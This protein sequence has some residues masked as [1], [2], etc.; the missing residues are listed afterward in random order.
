MRF[1]LK[2]I[3]TVLFIPFFLVLLIAITLRFQLL[4]PSFWENVFAVNGTYSKLSVSINKNLEAQTIAE[5][6][7]GSDVKIFTDLISPDN[8]KD[9]I[10]RNIVNFLAF[11]NGRANQII[12]YVPINKIPKSLLSANFTKLT[13]QM[14]LTDLLKEFNVSGIDLSQIQMISRAGTA[15]WVFLTASIIIS[16]LLL[17]ILYLLIDSGKRLLGPSIA[18]ILAGVAALA[19]FLLGTIIKVN[20]TKDLANSSNTGDAIIGTVAPPVIGGIL[21]VW[22]I[23]AI[24]VIILGIILLFIKKPRY[25]VRNKS[26]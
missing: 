7:V 20:W 17:Y 15:A 6:G 26:R 3:L 14:N 9:V 16:V 19:V 22:L 13:D 8:L 4:E 21:K 5:G 25:N 11:A 2:L 23:Y 24:V 18:L 10:N 1:V 12:V